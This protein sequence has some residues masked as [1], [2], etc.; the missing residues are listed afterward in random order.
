M[1]VAGL[2]AAVLMKVAGLKAAVLM[3]VTGSKAAGLM[4]GTVM[5]VKHS[6]SHRR[7]GLGLPVLESK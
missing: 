3:K 6:A 5:A 7:L 1:K 2:E 4:Q